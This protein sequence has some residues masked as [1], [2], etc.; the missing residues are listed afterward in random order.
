M[1]KVINGLRYDTDTAKVVASNDNGYY[2]NDFFYCEE[3]I[4]KTAKGNYFLHGEGGAASPYSRIC[5]SNSSCGGE[6]II[7]LTE[8]EVIEYL[9]QWNRVD[10]LEEFFPSYIQDA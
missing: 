6:D 2:R 8:S 3:T 9:E 10:K 1:K 7:L 4:Y 5:G